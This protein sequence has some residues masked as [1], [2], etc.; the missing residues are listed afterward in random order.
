MCC[1]LTIL[2]LLGPRVL[3]VFWWLFRPA[4]WNEAFTSMIW[5]ILGIIFVPWTTLM[6]M[7]LYR[8]GITGFEWIWIG[9]GLAAD[10]A[11]YGGGAYG[12][13]DQLPMYKSPTPPM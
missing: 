9:L 1:A 8:G 5:P 4:Y 10:I 3:N 6:Y 7:L 12:N 13:R 2:L 11:S